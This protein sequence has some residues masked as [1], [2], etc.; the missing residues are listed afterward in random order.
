[1]DS[2]KKH[3]AKERETK[4]NRRIGKPPAKASSRGLS[5]T[6]YQKDTP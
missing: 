5:P 4:R 2:I 3:A 6:L 1:M